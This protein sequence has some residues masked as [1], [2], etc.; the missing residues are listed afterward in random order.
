MKLLILTHVLS[1]IVGI[2]PTYASAVLLRP[3]Q[4]LPGLRAGLLFSK[5]LDLF[6]KIGGPTAVLSGLLLIW[7][8]H[9]GSLAQVWLLG[10]LAL[11]ALIQLVVI[12]Y[13]APRAQRLGRWLGTEG[14]SANAL[15]APQMGLLRQVNGAH[16]AAM[17]LGVLIFTLMILRPA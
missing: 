1:A 2:G 10:S 6:P 4:P 12:A 17:V 15:P 14:Q 5:R 13:L 3:G 8:G 16:T 9:Y 11:Y 7:L